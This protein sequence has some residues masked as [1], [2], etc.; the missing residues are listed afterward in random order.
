MK[1]YKKIIFLIPV[2]YYSALIGHF[3]VKNELTGEKIFTVL[4]ILPLAIIA[5]FQEEIKRRWFAP[6][7]KID[8]KL[9]A[10]FC[11]KTPLFWKNQNGNVVKETAAFYFRFG[12]TNV[13]ESQAKYCEAIIAELKENTDERWQDVD[14][15][16]QVNLK[17][18]RGK[19]EDAFIDIN[20]SPVRLLSD[21]G[22]I[23][24][25]PGTSDTQLNDRF[26]LNL[27]YGVGGFQPR[28]LLPKKK[29]RFEIIVVSEN[30]RYVTQKF[31][32]FRSGIWKDNPKEMFKEIS[33]KTI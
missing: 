14:Y 3:L 28:H 25:E 29:Y 15:F 23:T 26:Y 4:N 1:N 17:W 31:E 10:P 18:N 30:A 20:P 21:I 11:S 8:F 6:V 2:V 19:A 16:Q 33:I 7:L 24:K 9:D 32:F 27:W 5:L 12:V 22:F 13:G